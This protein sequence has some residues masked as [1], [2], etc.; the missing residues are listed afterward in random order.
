MKKIKACTD[1]DDA[2][3]VF[4]DPLVFSNILLKQLRRDVLNYKGDLRTALEKLREYVLKAS[5]EQMTVYAKITPVSGKW[6]IRALLM[7]DQII[8]LIWEE[9][10]STRVGIVA[11]DYLFNELY[12]KN[13]VVKLR[14]SLVPLDS[15]PQELAEYIT[16][17]IREKEKLRPPELWIKREVYG[18]IVDRLITSKGAYMYVLLGRDSFGRKYAIKIPREKTSDGKPLAIGGSVEPLAEVIRGLLNALEVYFSNRESLR[19]IL[20]T[21]G[22]D[23]SLADYLV[24]YRNY[25]LRPRAILLLRDVYSEEEYSEIP[26]VI[27]EEY[28]N[29][30]DLEKRVKNRPLDD[31][32]LA[33]LAIRVTGA[34]ALVHANQFIHMDI[35]PQNILLTESDEETYGYRPMVSDFVGLPHIFERATELKKTTPEYADPLALLRGYATYSYDVYS[36]GT[37]LYYAFT[38]MKIKTRLLLNLL[39]LKNLY[40]LPVP[41]KV[42]LIDNPNLVSVAKKLEAIFSNYIARGK[43]LPIDSLLAS[44]SATLADIDEEYMSPLNKLP[45]RLGSIIRR[46]LSLDETRRYN[47]SIAM[48]IDM[49][50]A[51]KEAG[52]R[53]LI[54]HRL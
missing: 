8:G 24:Y 36:L 5:K 17:C 34:L 3:N 23:E 33:F 11:Y 43:K 21:R 20:M 16:R 13:P 10:R 44:I 9:G 15:V 4:I 52:Y 53:H 27:V 31:R 47:D 46:S 26:P 14:A 2:S 41:L 12:E 22:Y 40:G 25:I 1:I 50:D 28:A 54:P 19:R 6:S 32:E 18:F 48:W 49:L 7:K 38:G 35:K 29:I 51:L 39:I 42:F 30:G 37:T 45:E